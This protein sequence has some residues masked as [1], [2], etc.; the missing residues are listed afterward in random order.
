LDGPSRNRI[1]CGEIV[2]GDA[3]VL[4]DGTEVLDRNDNMKLVFDIDFIKLIGFNGD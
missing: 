3:R 2:A 4:N 1:S